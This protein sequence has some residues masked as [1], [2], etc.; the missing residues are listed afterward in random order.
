MFNRFLNYN[1]ALTLSPL[2]LFFS[3]A[4]IQQLVLYLPWINDGALIVEWIKGKKK[5]IKKEKKRG[6]GYK[7]F[8]EVE[9]NFL[10]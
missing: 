9:K 5:K 6:K 7:T 3:Q 2:S 4:C 10:V 1:P 8:I